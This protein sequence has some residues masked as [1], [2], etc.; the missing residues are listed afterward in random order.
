MSTTFGYDMKEINFVKLGEQ[1]SSKRLE[2][3]VKNLPKQPALCHNAGGRPLEGKI[4]QGTKATTTASMP[5]FRTRS[6]V[7]MEEI[8]AL[9]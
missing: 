2:D 7:T 8:G 9:R 1:A 6:A 3:T 5:G 4:R